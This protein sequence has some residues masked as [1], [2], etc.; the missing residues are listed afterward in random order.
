MIKQHILPGTKKI[1]VLR[2]NGLGDFMFVLPALQAIRETY[3]QAEIVYLGKNWHKDFLHQRPSPIDKVI[4]IPNIK[5]VGEENNQLEDKKEQN[6]FFERMQQEQFDLALQL[7]G[8]GKYSNPFIKKLGAK[9]TAGLKTPDAEP[10]TIS[11]PYIYYQHEILRYLEVVS[12]IGATTSRI[13]PKVEITREEIEEAKPFLRHTS[14]AVLHP[15]ASDLRRRWHPERFAYLGDFLAQQG[16]PVYITGTKEEEETVSKVVSHMRKKAINLCSKL[17]L[18]GL[19]GLLSQTEIVIA[20]D[21]GPL[22]LAEALGTPT[23]GI[24]WCGNLINATPLT[25][26]LNRALPSWITIC[27][28]CGTDIARPGF[29]FEYEKTNCSHLTSFVNAVSTEEVISAVTHLL[30][31]TTITKKRYKDKPFHFFHK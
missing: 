1:A 16:L 11:I 17:S 20:N 15:G 10:L 4:A 23:V 21:T 18:R 22:H 24:Y 9:I 14:Y 29:P 28:L 3:P 5:G 12:F 31:Q 8:G 19:T 27:P 25:R 30:D 2:A 6:L 7:H 13:N 26:T